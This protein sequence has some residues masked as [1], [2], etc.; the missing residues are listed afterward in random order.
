MI[1]RSHFDLTEDELAELQR[2]DCTRCGRRAA[3]SRTK[4]N[5][6]MIGGPGRITTV[7]CIPCATAWS[8]RPKLRAMVEQVL[9]NARTPHAPVLWPGSVTCDVCL[10]T[11]DAPI[12]DPEART[13][14]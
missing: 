6:V 13:D 7:W 3:R 10:E 2:Q 5:L 1:G 11:A 12:H 14:R 4:A 8:R 9:A